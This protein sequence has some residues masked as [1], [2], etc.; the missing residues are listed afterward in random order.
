MDVT[1]VFAFFI[2]YKLCNSN[3]YSAWHCYHKRDFVDLQY[4]HF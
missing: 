1:I 2:F 3:M 4:I